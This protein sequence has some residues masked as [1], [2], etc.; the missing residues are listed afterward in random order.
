MK[1]I[2]LGII[3]IGN[4]GSA[5]AKNIIEG[6]CPEI[7]ICAIADIDPKRI[8]RAKQQGYGDNVAYFDDGIA[9][10]D[11]GLIDSCLIAVPHYDHASLAIECTLGTCCTSQPGQTGN[12][13]LWKLACVVHG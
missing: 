8:E 5:H 3:G 13:R 1:K 10:L 4:M 11:S 7:E 9:M 12:R 2:K 6:K